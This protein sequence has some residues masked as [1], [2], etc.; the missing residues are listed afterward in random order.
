MADTIIELGKYRF[1]KNYVFTLQDDK[2]LIFKH[3]NKIRKVIDT[4]AISIS[5]MNINFSCF[6]FFIEF[7]NII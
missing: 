1:P 3:E 4:S 6:I 2:D 5:N 7:Y